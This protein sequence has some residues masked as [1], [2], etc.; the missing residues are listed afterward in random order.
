[1]LGK[2]PD[3]KVVLAVDGG[4]SKGDVALVDGSGRVLAAGRRAGSYHFGLDHV[5]FDHYRPRETLARTIGIVAQKAGLGP[6]LKDIADIGV[7][8]VAGADIPID[9]RRIK[10]DLDRM[11]WAGKTIV[12]NDTFAVLRAGTD[13]KWGVAVVC[14]T[15][16][17][18]A[19]VGPDG[20]SVRFPSFGELSGDRAHGGGWLGRTALGAAIRARDGRG[21]RTALEQMIA[22]YF[23]MSRPT[24]VMEAVYTG[25]LDYDRLSELAPLV[26]RAAAQG[27]RISRDM[28][29]EMADEIVITVNAAIR[30][31]RLSDR[32]VHVVLG[33][34]VLRAGDK[35]LLDRVCAGIAAQAPKAVIRRLE[36]PP[37]VG[38][39][40]MAL[41]E[42]HAPPAAR[43]RLRET[44]THRRLIER[45][46]TVRRKG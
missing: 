44:L 13:R 28:I 30:R 41:D 24:A 34:G 11:G 22:A 35:S 42:L 45:G 20:R 38:A 7:Y 15:G 6:S 19:G 4:A 18:C 5:G 23:K 33:G 25:R 10:A 36:A 9:D 3:R 21:P 31:L 17:N 1:M 27:D 37:V 2:F 39:A 14:G 40:L 43:R 8:C 29:D 32:D 12:R 16:M 26:F 46:A